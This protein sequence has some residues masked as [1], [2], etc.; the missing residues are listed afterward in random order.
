MWGADEQAAKVLYYLSSYAF[1]HLY[2]FSD[3]FSSYFLASGSLTYTNPNAP[4]WGYWTFLAIGEVVNPNYSLPVGYYAEYFGPDKVL[5]SNIYTA[6]RGMIYDF[7]LIGSLACM[8]TM[9]AVVNY[10]YLR[11]L[12]HAK[13]FG[14]QAIFI[15][16][17]G[18]MYQSYI[19]SMFAWS[20]TI[21][22]AI[23]TAAILWSEERIGRIKPASFKSRG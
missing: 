13:A 20:S 9:G 14:S 15:F 17:L 6:F 10:A 3:W 8:A 1:G 7:T 23:L 4:T 11:M 18:W 22:A 21:G 19:F 12:T 16:T 5:Q 2:A